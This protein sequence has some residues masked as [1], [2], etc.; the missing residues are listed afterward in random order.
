MEFLL[1]GHDRELKNGSSIDVMA[2]W[3]PRNY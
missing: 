2:D 1:R 3:H